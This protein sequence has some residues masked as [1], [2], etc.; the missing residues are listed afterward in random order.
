MSESYVQSAVRLAAAN[1]G[2][3][4]WRNN[5]G[6]GKLADGSFVRWGLANDST[7]LNAQIKSA[8]LIG[9]RPL[10]ITPEMVGHTIGQFVSR[11]CKRVGWKPDRSERYLAQQRWADLVNRL[12][13]D[14]RFTTGE[15]S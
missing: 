14:A 9:I 11:E 13:G 3:I 15:W 2:A 8:D 6:A 12:G 7:A 4:L 5:N 1:A 10:L